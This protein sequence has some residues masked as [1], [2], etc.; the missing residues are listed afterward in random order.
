MPVLPTKSDPSP[1]SAKAVQINQK[2]HAGK[3]L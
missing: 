2:D 1:V 3:D